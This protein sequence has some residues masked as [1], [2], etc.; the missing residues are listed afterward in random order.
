QE[1]RPSYVPV[2][3][4]FNKVVPFLPICEDSSINKP[5]FGGE[6]RPSRGLEATVRNDTHLRRRNSPVHNHM[7]LHR[8][9]D[10]NQSV[11]VLRSILL[12]SLHVLECRSTMLVGGFRRCPDS[13]KM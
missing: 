9:A 3:R 7:S 6:Y 11:G 1:L 2:S 8:F 5:W 4:H 12:Y 13:S 10:D